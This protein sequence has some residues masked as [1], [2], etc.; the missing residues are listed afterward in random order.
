MARFRIVQRPRRDDSSLSLYEVEKHLWLWRWKYE[1]L[2]FDL[3][4]AERF[5]RAQLNA[6][7]KAAIKRRVLGEYTLNN[8]PPGPPPLSFK[9]TPNP[10]SKEP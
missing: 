1:C 2:F 9:K 8:P 4:Q 6:S 5:V 3:A 7:I 10:P